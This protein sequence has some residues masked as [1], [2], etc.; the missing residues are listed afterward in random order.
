MI[1][2]SALIYMGVLLYSAD[3]I[4]PPILPP[5]IHIYLCRPQWILGWPD[6]FEGACLT[7]FPIVL[8]KSEVEKP[9]K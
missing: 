3:C 7:F 6:F 1:P 5:T 9:W 8:I 2:L 4:G